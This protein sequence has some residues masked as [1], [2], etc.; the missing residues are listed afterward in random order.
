MNVQ[1]EKT[2]LISNWS[3]DTS[4]AIIDQLKLSKLSG[5]TWKDYND[6]INLMLPTFQ[7]YE[8]PI[9]F[10]DTKVHQMYWNLLCRTI[11]TMHCLIYYYTIEKH[12]QQPSSLHKINIFNSQL[13]EVFEIISVYR[14]DVYI[15]TMSQHQIKLPIPYLSTSNDWCGDWC[16]KFATVGWLEAVYLLCSKQWITPYSACFGFMCKLNTSTINYILNYIRNQNATASQFIEH[17]CETWMKCKTELS[18]YVFQLV[19]YEQIIPK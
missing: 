4:R 17:F 7:G 8:L 11:V 15:F 13:K 10:A 18:S 14:L 2:I 1:M 19:P 12:N 6:M 3:F 9:T 5:F 16:T